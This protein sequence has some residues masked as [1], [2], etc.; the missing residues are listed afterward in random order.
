MSNAAAHTCNLHCPVRWGLP[1]EAISDLGARLHRFWQRFRG[2]FST[3]TRDPSPLAFDYLRALLTVN[4]G[5][6]FANI[7]RR[8]H[9]GDG[10]RLQ[11]FMSNSPWSGPAV[12]AQIRRELIST[13]ELS[14]GGTLILDECADEKAGEDSAGVARQYNGRIGSIDLCRVD[15]CLV[16]ANLSRRLWTMIDGEMFVARHWFA[17]EYCRRREQTGIPQDRQFATKLALGLRMIERSRA[18]G[19]RFDVVACDSLYGRDHRFRSALHAAGITYAAQVPASTLVRTGA[20]PGGRA[21]TPATVVRAREVRELARDR[22]TR[23]RRFRLRYSERGLLSADFALFRVRVAVGGPPTVAAATGEAEWLVIRKISEQ[24]RYGYTL[25]NAPADAPVEHVVELSARR[26]FVERTFQ[27]AKS[28]LGWAEFQARKYRAWEHHLALVAAALWF[29]AQTKLAWEREHRRDIRLTLEMGVAV[30]PALSTA[31]LREL[32]RAVL[33]L[34]QLTTAD[35]AQSVVKHLVR[36]ARSISA[37][38]RSITGRI[39]SS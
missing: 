32:L 21:C 19:L 26:C 10:Q 27:D 20:V 17:D 12:F 37:R 33:P 22:R 14:E 13:P 34:A 16:Y 31:N 2:C 4:R 36:R 7:E 35:A 29:A 30:L 6:N 24:R 1:A 15:T 11:H 3:R 38:L 9:G 39:D 8:L 23:W 18:E 5:R 28:E 25:V